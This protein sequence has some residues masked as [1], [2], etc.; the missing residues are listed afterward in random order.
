M[1]ALWK[2][3]TAAERSSYVRQ[4][5]PELTERQTAADRSRC[6]R[7]TSRRWPVRAG[8]RPSRPPSSN[9]SA[10]TRP[11]RCPITRPK[12]VARS[13]SLR[14]PSLDESLPRNGDSWVAAGVRARD[15]L[16]RCPLRAD[17]G[18]AIPRQPARASQ[19]RQTVACPPERRAGGLAP[20][21]IPS[22]VPRRAPPEGPSDPPPPLTGALQ[23]LIA[24]PRHAPHH[25]HLRLRLVEL[26]L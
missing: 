23:L 25:S 18:L 8:H 22:S 15:V 14:R 3:Q 19:R 4:S 13:A 9:P 17:A 7:L 20:G 5:L 6:S 1:E 16:D 11:R 10:A 26:L 2:R 21:A 12:D 24:L